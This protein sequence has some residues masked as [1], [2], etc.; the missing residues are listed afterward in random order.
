MRPW[1]RPSRPRSTISRCSST[2]KTSPRLPAP[3]WKSVSPTLPA[4]RRIA[5][6]CAPSAPRELRRTLFLKRG[7]TFLGIL[8]V[9]CD[10]NRVEFQVDELIKAA[11]VRVEHALCES[12]G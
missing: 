4:D 9:R 11:H 2:P 1:I 5:V 7:H 8:R 10:G 12:E 3:S 6:R